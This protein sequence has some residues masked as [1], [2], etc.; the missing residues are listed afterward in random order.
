MAE[1]PPKANWTRFSSVTLNQPPPGFQMTRSDPRVGG[2]TRPGRIELKK[3]AQKQQL[4]QKL[5]KILKDNKVQ[6]PHK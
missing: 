1:K 3:N 4:H 6:I 2:S 5:H